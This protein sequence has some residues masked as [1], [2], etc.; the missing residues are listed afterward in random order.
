MLIQANMPDFFWTEVISI[1]IYLKNRLSSEVIDDDI[2]FKYWFNE[3]L[4]S[5]ELKILKSFDYI[6]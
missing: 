5:D 2:S 6:I 3:P 4:D 1:V